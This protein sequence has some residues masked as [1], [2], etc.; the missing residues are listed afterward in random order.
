LLIYQATKF[1]L[2]Q[3]ESKKSQAEDHEALRQL[4]Q[5]YN[6]LVFQTKQIQQSIAKKR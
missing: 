2:L 6:T 3:K 1:E 4:Y 5:K